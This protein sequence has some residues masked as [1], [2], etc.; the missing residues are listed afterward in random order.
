LDDEITLS[1]DRVMH[2][3]GVAEMMAEL[4]SMVGAESGM[5]PEGAFVLGL[6]HDVGYA[7]CDEPKEHA[8]IG[9][10]FLRYQHYPLWREVYWH[11]L[12]Q[13]EYGSRQLVMLNTC[14]MMVDGHGKR[15]SMDDRLVDIADRYGKE[16][17]QLESA[18]AMLGFVQETMSSVP[19]MRDALARME[20]GKDA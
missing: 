6:V 16:S 3:R 15:V 7:L 17:P 10:E 12:V 20:I 5:T 1:K 8:R 18:K 13:T 9:G 11:G 2:M 14:D 4:T 19:M